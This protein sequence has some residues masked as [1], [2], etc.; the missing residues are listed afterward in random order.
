MTFKTL[1]IYRLHQ[2]SAIVNHA[3]RYYNLKENPLL[4]AGKVG[5]PHSSEMQFWTKE[6]YL[7][8]SDTIM[9][10]P[11]SFTAFEVLYWT[12][13]R[14]G[15]LLALTPADFDFERRL[16]RIDKSYQ[17]LERQDV[18]TTPKTPKSNRTIAMPDFVADEVADYIELYGIQDDERVFPMTK[19]GLYH[20]MTRGATASGVK[21]I[22]IHDL[23]H[24]H[25]SLLIVSGK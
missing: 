14:E 21:R 9:D 17:R 3:I 25:V 10:K 20:E 7:R 1:I 15:E 19:S 8:F 2:L 6:E 4:R 22:R 16:L 18:I 24:S 23:R 11:Q 13:C 5:K 12:G